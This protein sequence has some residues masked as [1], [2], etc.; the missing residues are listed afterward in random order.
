M[1]S[2]FAKKAAEEEEEE[3]DDDANKRTFNFKLK[4]MYSPI[5]KNNFEN[6]IPNIATTIDQENAVSTRRDVF[7]EIKNFEVI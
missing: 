6:D 1:G 7:D 2:M 5:K 3:K 4:K